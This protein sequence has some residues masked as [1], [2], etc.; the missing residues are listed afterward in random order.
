VKRVSVVTGAGRGLGRQVAIALATRG[1]AVALLARSKSQLDET[2]R[3]IG[4]AARAYPVDV[5]DPE[6]VSSVADAI[7][8]ELG[9]VSVLVN[10]AGVFGPIQLVKDS[11]PAAWIATI[12]ANVVGPYLT[13][14]SFV[15]GMLRQKWGR[16]VNFSSA[17][18]FHPPGPLNSAYGTSKVALNHFTRHLAAE[19]AGRGVTVNV[20][21]P[22][23]VKTEMW[24]DIR[25]Q[26]AGLGPE[27]EGY[28][29]WVEWVGETG[30][31]DPKK[32][33]ELVLKLTSAESND[34]NGQFLW[35]EG[36]LQA[37]IKGW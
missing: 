5:S 27:G 28:R 22:G 2:Q 24:A 19:V 37:P 10:A 11:E 21:H 6:A 23:E 12:N 34:V 15:G 16:I 35:I 17:A 8:K 9:T 18:A 32:A 4:D 1:D 33:A 7:A 13:C 3:A 14:R 26:A 36:G 25:D 30:G 31:D 29:K 20:I